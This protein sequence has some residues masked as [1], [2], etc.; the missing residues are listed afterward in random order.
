MGYVVGK[1]TIEQ[2]FVVHCFYFTRPESSYHC[3]TSLFNWTPA[4][5]EVAF[6][7]ETT[8]KVIVSHFALKA[9]G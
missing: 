9:W 8:P 2:V 6:R 3:T 4:E 1:G 5:R 7:L